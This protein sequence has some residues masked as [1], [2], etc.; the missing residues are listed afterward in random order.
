MNIMDANIPEEIQEKLKIIER[1]AGL[2][3]PGFDIST[4]E[5]HTFID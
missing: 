2:S 5:V 4:K 1:E 3:N